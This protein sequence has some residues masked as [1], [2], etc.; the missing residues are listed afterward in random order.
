VRYPCTFPAEAP[1]GPPPRRHPKEQL[2]TN[3][4]LANRTYPPCMTGSLSDRS[5]LHRKANKA[6]DQ[7]LVPGESVEVVIIGANHQAIIGTSRRAFVFKKGLV[8]GASFGS[9][10]TSW[11]YRNLNGVQIHTGMMTGAVV[12]QAPGQSGMKTNYWKNSDSD[13]YKAPNAIPIVRP[14]GPAKEGVA[15]LRQLMD[16][17]HQAGQQA[18]TEAAPL[19]NAD[20]MAQLKQLGELRDA[21]AVTPEE[22][23][24]K[25]GLFC[26]IRGWV[27]GP[28]MSNT[29]FP[30]RFWAV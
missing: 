25:K 10:L 6:L 1:R 4:N 17:A 11:D 26:R 27:L 12:L 20:P 29:P 2:P 22:F 8:A 24:A 9:E 7:N 18:P 23:E 16:A 15:R 21:G 3:A 19:L 14:W 28:L 13:P 30:L 5:H